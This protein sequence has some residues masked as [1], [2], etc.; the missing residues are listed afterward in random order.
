MERSYLQRVFESQMD[1]K[2]QFL[3]KVRPGKSMHVLGVS[4]SL[5]VSNI[6]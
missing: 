2:D 5:T 1:C 4:V 6:L 3:L